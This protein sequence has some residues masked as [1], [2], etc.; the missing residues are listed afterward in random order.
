MRWDERRGCSRL[1]RESTRE[2]SSAAA[3]WLLAAALA[4]C[5]VAPPDAASARDDPAFAGW[6]IFG[7]TYGLPASIGLASAIGA[8]HPSR[9]DRMIYA[10]LMTPVFGPVM[11][12]GLIIEEH[13]LTAVAALFCVGFAVVQATGL[14]MAISAHV[15]EGPRRHRCRR[16]Q[17]QLRLAPT[18]GPTGVGLVGVF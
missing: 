11:V 12:A 13:P 2:R 6:L 10:G 17:R 7:V 8:D 14:Y 18:V 3:I 16:A 1:K 4:V 5:V 9:E 15:R